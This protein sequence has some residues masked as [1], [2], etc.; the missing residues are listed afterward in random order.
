MP[1]PPVRKNLPAGLAELFVFALALIFAL[2]VRYAFR[3]YLTSDYDSFTSLWYQAV[4]EQGFAAAG[5]A[6]SNYTPPYM[7]LLYLTSVALP[8]LAPVIAIKVPSILF[9]FFCAWFVFRIVQLKYQGLRMPLFAAMAVLLAPTVVSNSGIWGQ[10]DSIY[11]SMLLAC[12]YFVMTGRGA[13][14]AVAFGMALSFKF[15]AM[16]LAPAM[17]VLLLKRVVPLWTVVLVPLVYALVMVPAWLAGRPAWDLATVYLTQSVTYH[18]LSKNAPNFYLWLP[19]RFYTPAVLGGLLLTVAAGCVYLWSAWKSK[20][21]LDQG[22]ILQLCLLSLIMA[23]FL[24]PKMHDRFFYPADVLAIAY[25]FFFP[26]QYYVPIAVSFASFFAYQPFLAR[27]EV[28]PLKLLPIVM[29]VAFVAVAL[30]TRRS[31]RG[32][33]EVT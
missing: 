21:K 22:L 23:P 9:D 13:V 14:A 11:A 5:T 32:S 24:L 2:Y 25:G 10:A 26:R 19:D 12:V 29:L 3:S 17:C 7:Y 28:V 18:S 4:K 1:T 27:L 6:V 20:V 16:F 30:S 15:Q 33:P 31:L 8:K